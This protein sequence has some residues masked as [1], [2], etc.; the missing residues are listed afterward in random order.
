VFPAAGPAAPGRP[1]ASGPGRPEP[2][3]RG[4]R[5]QRPGAAG[6]SGPGRP[7]GG[8]A[9]AIALR[10]AREESGLTRQWAVPARRQP[11]RAGGALR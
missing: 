6:A 2:A 3:A 1:G 11:V 9:L 5:S 7:C 4:G 8:Q 10:E